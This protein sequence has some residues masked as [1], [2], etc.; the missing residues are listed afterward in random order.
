MKK[1]LFLA[2]F[3]LVIENATAQNQGTNLYIALSL[4]EPLVVKNVYKHMHAPITRPRMK[5]CGIGKIEINSSTYFYFMQY[6]VYYGRDL[7]LT[8]KA[9]TTV[10][11]IAISQIAS[12][13]PTARTAA[14][15]DLDMQ[16]AIDYDY[17]HQIDIYQDEVN[18]PH[19]IE[20]LK[21]FDKIFVIEYLSNGNAKIVECEIT[22]RF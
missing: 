1:Y 16:P 22:T 21:S 9:G 6:P 15:L 20:Y 10:Q 2:I 13:Y 3:L 5:Q 4:N 18:T 8:P 14:Q 12:L 17:T 19:T 7:E 11:T